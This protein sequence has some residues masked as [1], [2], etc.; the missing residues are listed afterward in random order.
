MTFIRQFLIAVA[1]SI[2]SAGPAIDHSRRSFIAALLLGALAVSSLPIDSNAVVR[3]EDY[4]VSTWATAPVSAAPTDAN[5]INNQTIRNVVHL[6]VGGDK[7]RVKFSNRYGTAPLVVNAASVAVRAGDETIVVGSNRQ[8]TFGG[9]TSF[10]I[11]ING[12]L[13]SDWADLRVTD[14]ADLAVDLY[15]SI[16]TSASTSPLTLHNARP[17]GQ[18]L[19][20]LATGNQVGVTTL[21]T[22]ATRTMWYFTVG[23]DVAAP[24]AVGAIVAFGDSIT[25]GSASTLNANARWPDFLARRIAAQ[26]EIRPMGVPNLGIGGNRVLMGGTGEN[27][28][29]RFDRDALV[30][31]GATHIIVLE[32]I[33][34]ISGLN[35]A[36]R[37]IEGHRQ[38]I[39]RAHARG[40]KI[41]GATVTPF[42]NA[43]DA[44]EQQRLI[45]ND[46]IRNS[47][48]YDAV[49]DFDAAVRDPANP[50]RMLPQ[51]DSGDTLHPNSAGYEAMANAI[52]LNLFKP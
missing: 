9:F 47:G 42:A 51:Y 24:K 12:E 26:T 7:V 37:I 21:P 11:P 35:T 30:Q 10:T 6:S 28:L 5:R 27:A 15:L 41:Y 13:W 50:R 48:H 16:D 19:S 36:D 34:D 29:A 49:I 22:E 17:A 8:L 23:V 20:Y 39:K 52:D 32:G 3:T 18:I 46:W 45:L 44:R 2:R 14:Q 25:D 4:S 31:T 40:L 38:L 1:R 43:P 33:N